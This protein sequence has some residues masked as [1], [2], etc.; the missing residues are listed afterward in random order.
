MNNIWILKNQNDGENWL[1]IE[2]GW[3]RPKMVMIKIQLLNYKRLHQQ[4]GKR[5]QASRIQNHENDQCQT[6]KLKFAH[7]K[8]IQCNDKLNINFARWKMK[9]FK[10]I[11]WESLREMNKET[12]ETHGM[13][14]LVQMIMFPDS[15]LILKNIIILSKQKCFGAFNKTICALFTRSIWQH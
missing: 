7:I 6:T 2:F 1:K 13:I 10:I 9:H 4:F 3:R 15:K 5:S 14:E 11:I 12:R 8:E